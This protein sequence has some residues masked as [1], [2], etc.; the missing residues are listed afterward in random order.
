MGNSR[1]TNTSL[2]GTLQFLGAGDVVAF[3]SP[4]GQGI[5]NSQAEMSEAT[6]MQAWKGSATLKE[7]LQ[8]LTVTGV[9]H[10]RHPL[11]AYPGR[12]ER[13]LADSVHN[14]HTSGDALEND[15]RYVCCHR[16]VGNQ[17]GVPRRLPMPI[18]ATMEYLQSTVL[19]HCKRFPLSIQCPVLTTYS[20]PSER[21]MHR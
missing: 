19:G 1:A 12:C 2:I 11:R 14:S 20:A 4:A 17:R 16:G 7:K 10:W 5:G 9:V 15:V 8:S 3:L 21:T 6:I 18:A 13:F